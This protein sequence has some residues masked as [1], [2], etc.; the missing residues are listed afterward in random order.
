MLLHLPPGLNISTISRLYAKECSDL[1]KST[2]GCPSKLSSINVCHVI[3]L[4]ST[5]RAKNAVQVTKALTNI[6]NQPIHPNTICQH[7]KKT[8]MK[9]VVKQKRP[10]LS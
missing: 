8:G 7:L 2:G 4:I 1:Q 6:I 5:R 3:H 9:A 10:I